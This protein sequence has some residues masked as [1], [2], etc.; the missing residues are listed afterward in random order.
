MPRGRLTFAD[1][2]ADA[3]LAGARHAVLVVVDV[4]GVRVDRDLG[5]HVD[6]D[7]SPAVADAHDPGGRGVGAGEDAVGLCLADGGQRAALVGMVVAVLVDGRR[8][9]RVGQ[10]HVIGETV[11]H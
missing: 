4:E 9:Q 2:D 11:A 8:H 1:L 6:R 7:D 10:T 5:L 3:R